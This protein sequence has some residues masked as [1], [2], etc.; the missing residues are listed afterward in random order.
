MLKAHLIG[1]VDVPEQ[2][3]LLRDF[4]EMVAGFKQKGLLDASAFYYTRKFVEVLAMLAT[5]VYLLANYSDCWAAVAAACV[6]QGTMFLQCG[7]LQHDFNH[8]AV[9]A[10]AAAVCV[11]VRILLAMAHGAA[12]DVK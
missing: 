10:A 6:L 3:A 4:H 7:W 5:V 9:S 8:N 11:H 12:E 1:E 2:A